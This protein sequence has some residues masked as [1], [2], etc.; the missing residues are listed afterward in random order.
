MALN[1]L[2]AVFLLTHMLVERRNLLSFG[3]LSAAIGT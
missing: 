1:Y 3:L 2:P